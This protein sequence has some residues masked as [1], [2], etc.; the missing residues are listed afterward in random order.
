MIAVSIIVMLSAISC[1]TAPHSFSADP[2][3][4]LGAD[5]PWYAV[6]PV[7]ENRSVLEAFSRTLTD[8]KSFMKGME[9]AEVLYLAGLPRNSAGDAETAFSIVATG[10]FPVKMSRLAFPEKD[11]WEKKGSRKDGVWYENGSTAVAIPGPGLL[12]MSTPEYLSRMLEAVRNPPSEDVSVD[13]TFRNTVPRSGSGDGTI[14]LYIR[15]RQFIKNTFLD[16][17]ELE[18]PIQGM[19][20]TARRIPGHSEYRLVIRIHYPDER[21]T[22]A[23]LPLVRLVLS[24]SVTQDGT[25]HRLEMQVKPEDIADLLGFVYF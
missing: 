20:V 12:C 25:T 18:L 16:T 4:I 19:L 23:L 8:S 22:R 3:G 2:L 24:G 6:F 17:V 21:T 11:G 5:A 14:A 10:S 15:D 1:A 7:D 9:R 13:D